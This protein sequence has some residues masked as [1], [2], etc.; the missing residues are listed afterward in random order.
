MIREPLDCE[1]W[2]EGRTI[3]VTGAYGYIGAGLCARLRAAGAQLRRATRGRSEAREDPQAWVGDLRD[4]SFVRKLV[5]GA[6]AVFHLAGQTSV[7]SANEDP[8][9]DLQANVGS[10]L[11]LLV[12]CE[13]AGQRPAFVYSGTAT[14]IGLTTQVPIPPGTQDLPATVYDAHKLAAEH[15]VGVYVDKGAVRGTTLRI[16]NVFGP[17]AA[18]SAPDRGVTNRVIARALAGGELTY[19]GDGQLVRDY[20]YIDDLLDA[21]FRAAPYASRATRRSYVVARGEGYTLRDTFN[22]I[23]EVVAELGY[24]KV[25]VRSVDWPSTS[26]PIDRRSF[27]ADIEPTIELLDWRPIVTLREGLRLTAQFL[28]ASHSQASQS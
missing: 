8:L 22:L 21:F 1:D 2:Y 3:A 27:V 20:V 13:A 7:S 28:C 26:H 4:A 11:N 17:G 19:Y 10:T 15:L 12:A 14:E 5:S 24:P 16:A 18:K 9:A 25:N 23:A 6:D